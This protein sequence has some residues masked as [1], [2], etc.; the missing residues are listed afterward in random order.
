MQNYTA[1]QQIRMLHVTG[2]YAVKMTAVRYGFTLGLLCVAIKMINTPLP[3]RVPVN[4]NVP[5]SKQQEEM[6]RV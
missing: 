6:S 2:D 3:V 4:P 5:V 1:D